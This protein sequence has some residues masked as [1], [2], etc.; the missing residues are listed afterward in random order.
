[1]QSKLIS[2]YHDGQSFHNSAFVPVSSLNSGD[3]NSIKNNYLNDQSKAPNLLIYGTNA[4]LNQHERQ[5]QTF[6]QAS[7]FPSLNQAVMQ[8]NASLNAKSEHPA[9]VK[10]S[11]K[12]VKVVHQ[13]QESISESN[14]R[15]PRKMDTSRGNVQTRYKND[16]QSDDEDED[17]DDDY[18]PDADLFK[19]KPKKKQSTAQAAMSP[20][21]QTPASFISKI[22]REIKAEVKE[23]AKDEKIDTMLTPASQIKFASSIKPTGKDQAVK[24]QPMADV[25]K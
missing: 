15:T 23:E 11:V 9:E 17:E 1:M 25:Q 20:T 16:G 5:Q 14:K 18:D 7:M 19:N 24:M 8:G 10:K 6:P 3:I 12:L 21:P 2:P 13:T 4:Y 22:K